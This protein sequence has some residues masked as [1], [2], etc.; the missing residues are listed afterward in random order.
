[1][2]IRTNHKEFVA[3][4]KEI[5]ACDE[6]IDYVTKN[7]YT[8]VSAWNNCDRAGWMLWL[9]CKL[10]LFTPKLRIYAIC[11]CAKTALKYV[12]T[13]ENRPADAICAAI[14]CADDPTKA[15]MEAAAEA[16]GA[17]AWAAEAAGAAEAAARAATRAAGAAA[18]AAWAAEAAGA[19][20]WAAWAAE[21]AAGAAAWAAEAAA[22]KKMCKLIRKRLPMR[23]GK[24]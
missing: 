6:A 14:K 5:S 24:E 17:A 20:A 22:H 16:A 23:G 15:N 18:E 7:K 19:A 11:D 4:L 8:L 10:E 1:M 2:S 21:A 9:V 3:K 12:P 13:G